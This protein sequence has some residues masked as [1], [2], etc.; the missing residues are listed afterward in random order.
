MFRQYPNRATRISLVV[1]MTLQ[2]GLNSLLMA[3]SASA[4]QPTEEQVFVPP[5]VKSVDKNRLRTMARPR[6]VSNPEK[7]RSLKNVQ[8]VTP[9]IKTKRI[10][11]TVLRLT[12]RR[13]FALAGYWYFNGVAFFT[14]R[15]FDEDEGVALFV[16]PEPVGSQM[17]LRFTGQPGQRYAVDVTLGIGGNP[18]TNTYRVGCA[19][20][21]VPGPTKTI[22][23][24]NGPTEHLFFDLAPSTSGQYMVSVSCDQMTSWW[25]FSSLE[26][27]L[28]K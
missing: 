24:G 9:I 15:W 27:G 7:L 18:G 28:L 13:S 21:G 19:V 16:N 5:A 20:D 3:P 10:W 6:Q 11:Q 17:V 22:Q 8:N 2:F 23:V 26:L 14:P 1:L 25:F 4:Q 12:P